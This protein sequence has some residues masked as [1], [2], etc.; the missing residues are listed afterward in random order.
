MREGCR[1]GDKGRA[2]ITFSC[3][4]VLLLAV[5]HGTNWFSYM[6]HR[7]SAMAAGHWCWLCCTVGRDCKCFLQVTQGTWHLSGTGHQLCFSA[8][9]FTPESFI[10][11]SYFKFLS[12][13]LG[14]NKEHSSFL[15]WGGK[16]GGS[17][18]PDLTIA[19]Q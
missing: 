17:G 9:V 19:S 6:S 2:K 8:N 13:P 15:V 10:V 7:L 5:S 16:T 1:Y 18:R 11:A 12:F 4:L 3:G 14:D